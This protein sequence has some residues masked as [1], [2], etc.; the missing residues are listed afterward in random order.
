MCGGRHRDSARAGP[1]VRAVAVHFLILMWHIQLSSIVQTAMWAT[2]VSV[3]RHVR[4]MSLCFV[5]CSI[6]AL[7]MPVVVP[8]PTGVTPTACLVA[9]VV[10]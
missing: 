9:D 8:V 4:A 5:V 10:H 7:L 3:S 6:C 1:G 2:P